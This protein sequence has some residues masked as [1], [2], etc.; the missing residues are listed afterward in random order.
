MFHSKYLYVESYIIHIRD[1]LVDLNIRCRIEKI[2][3]KNIPI[4]DTSLIICFEDLTH[5]LSQQFVEPVSIVIVNE[6]ILV[7]STIFVVPKS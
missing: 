2:S 5:F 3:E 1:F 4:T 6:T 7:N